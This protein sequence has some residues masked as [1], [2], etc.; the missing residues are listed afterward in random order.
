MASKGEMRC[1]HVS[2]CSTSKK[3]SLGG[4]M[5]ASLICVNATA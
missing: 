2:C 1:K 5:V 3:D 4:W